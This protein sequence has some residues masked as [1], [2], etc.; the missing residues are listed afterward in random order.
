[1]ATRYTSLSSEIR[2]LEGSATGIDGLSSEAFTKHTDVDSI[3]YLNSNHRH[4]FADFLLS[5]ATQ[6]N[7]RDKN[8]IVSLFLIPRVENAFSIV[9]TPTL[10]TTDMFNAY[11]AGCAVF[12]ESADPRIAVI[13]GIRLPPFNFF[14]V[15][16]NQTGQALAGTGNVLSMYTYGYEDVF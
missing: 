11:Y 15:L 8:A 12:D 9:I 3:E 10:S 4:I 6:A 13:S 1:M 16:R 14:P 5:I 2:L 7:P